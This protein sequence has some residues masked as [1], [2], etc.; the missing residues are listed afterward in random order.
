MTPTRGQLAELTGLGKLETVSRALTTLEK[1]GWIDREHVPVTKAGRRTA[2]LLRI[3]VRGDAILSLRK[4]R[5]TG[6]TEAVVSLGG[7]GTRFR[8]ARK[9]GATGR[10]AVE[11]Q[12]RAKGR[13]P[14]TGQDFPKGKGTCPTAVPPPLPAGGQ[15]T[16][17]GASGAEE[18]K[19]CEQE[20]DGPSRSLVDLAK[21]AC[22]GRS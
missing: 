8:K 5:K 14:K 13:A 22:G 7:T 20:P 15:R 1:A 21:E 10:N 2:T 17:G 19:A 4:A 16:L 6:A 11:H 12:K 18:I 3:V 9:T